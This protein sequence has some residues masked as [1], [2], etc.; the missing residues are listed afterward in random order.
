[1]ADELPSKPSVSWPRLLSGLKGQSAII[2]TLITVGMAYFP[3]KGMTAEQVSSFYSW[4]PAIL[5][6]LWGGVI[7]GTAYEDAKV[8][9]PPL[10]VDATIKT[11]PAPQAPAADPPAKANPFQRPPTK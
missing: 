3:P 9:A 7:G 4:L 5:T 6:V 8:K 10:E 2:G 1:M 11:D